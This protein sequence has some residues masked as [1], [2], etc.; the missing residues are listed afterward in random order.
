MKPFS[1]TT[2]AVLIPLAV[3]SLLPNLSFAQALAN[4]ECSGAAVISSPPF[5]AMQDTRLATANPSDPVLSCADGGGGKTVWFSYTADSTRYIKFSTLGSTPADYDIAMALFTGACGSLVE[6]RC[7]DD[8][9]GTRQSEIIY[10]VQAGTTYIIHI[11]EWF[12]GGPNGGVPTGG[13]LVFNVTV[14]TPL[15]A[16]GPKSGS[17]VSGVIVNTNS[18]PGSPVFGKPGE[19]VIPKNPYIPP[20]L[21]PKNVMKPLGPEGSNYIEDR[22]LSSL[23]ASAGRPVVQTSFQG[24]P[25]LGVVIPPDPIMAVGPNHIVACVNQ[26]FRIFD[27]NGTALKTISTTGSSGWFATTRS[28][29]SAFDP[30]I[31]YDHFANRWV[32]V[33][34]NLTSTTG[35]F[36]IS[37]S[38]DSDPLGTWYNWAIPSTTVGDSATPYWGDYEHIGYDSL[39][40]YIT[41]NQFTFADN[42]QYVKVRIIP[43]A[44]LYAKTAGQLTWKDLWDLRDPND[45]SVVVFTVMPSIVYGSPSGYFLVNGSPFTLGTYF[46]I[47][48]I[49]NPLTTPAMTAVN[50]PVFAYSE[51]PNANQLGGS[52]ILIEAGGSSILT[53]AT[54]RDGSLWAVHS[55]ASGTGN[56]YS[57][58][59]YVRFDPFT[60]TN[61]EDVAMGIDGYWHFY[62]TIMADQDKNLVLG[63]SRSGINEYIGAY[64]SGRKDTDPPGLSP[65]VVLKAGEANYVKT[66]GGT[67]NRW[68]DYNG[69]GLDPSD[70]NAVWAFT[71]YAASPANT[72]GTWVGKVKID[73]LRSVFINVPRTSFTLRT[74]EVGQRSDTATVV[75]SNVGADTLV[76]SNISGPSSPFVLINPPSV[77]LAIPAG[78]ISFGVNFVPVGTGTFTDSLIISSN[79]TANPT[80]TVRLTATSFVVQPAVR[81]VMYATS[82]TSTIQGKLYTV[83]TSTAVTTQVGPDRKSV[84]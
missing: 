70:G 45:L 79:D 48:T 84:V 52:S 38:D 41:S 23:P 32:M 8:A 2:F 1:L 20:L 17:V 16:L 26:R 53:S 7:N 63:Y 21:A 28:G 75:I 27:K 19:Q 34:D 82:G 5:N 39:A 13:T 74:T 6:V 36:L 71:E 77:P 60:A 3:N 42:F 56:A 33:W 58:V 14:T 80:V 10:Q 22:G 50:V 83:D 72:W 59:H 81:G 9:G 51:A 49:T 15:I 57:A 46:T 18:F 40:L 35:H 73:T 31:I 68:G 76:I 43:K 11:G 25:D 78:S 62:P 37:V 65:S 61:L 29:A 55:V 4:D 30:Q 67:R 66:F 24:I 69:I 54:Y 12:G 44:Q 47:R 64:L